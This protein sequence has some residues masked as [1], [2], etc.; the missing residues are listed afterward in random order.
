MSQTITSTEIN[1]H[2]T[3]YQDE[4][5]REVTLHELIDAVTEVSENEHEVV[6]TVTHMLN[7]GRVRLSSNFR[8]TSLSALCN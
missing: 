4:E 8:D 3:T 6:A 1:Q 2:L 5:S 7:S